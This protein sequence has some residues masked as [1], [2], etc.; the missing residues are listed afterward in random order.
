MTFALTGSRTSDKILDRLN[1]QAIL[2]EKIKKFFGVRLEEY[3]VLNV[4]FFNPLHVFDAHAA[5]APIPLHHCRFLSYSIMTHDTYFRFLS[6]REKFVVQEYSFPTN[7]IIPS[8]G[9]MSA[10]SN[11]SDKESAGIISRKQF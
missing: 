10:L 3:I 6:T 11:C 4:F 2:D 8:Y 9:E 1:R 5:C 7:T